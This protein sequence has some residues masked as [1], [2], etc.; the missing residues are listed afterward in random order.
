MKQVKEYGYYLSTRPR[1]SILLALRQSGGTNIILKRRNCGS[2]FFS[3]ALP[4]TD[5]R[6]ANI[7]R[8]LAAYV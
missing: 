1:N 5:N 6:I 4:E 2:W 3:F 8:L 7:E